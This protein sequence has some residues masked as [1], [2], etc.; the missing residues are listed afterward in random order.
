MNGANRNI[1]ALISA[2]LG[3]I[4][5]SLSSEP[6]LAV[7]LQEIRPTEKQ[8]TSGPGGRVLTNVGVWSPDSE[9]IVYDTRSDAAGDVFDGTRIEMVNIHTREVK[10]LYEAHHGACCGVATFH[11][12]EYKVIFILGPENPTVDWRYGP[13]HRQGVIVDVLKPGAAR[14]LDARDLTAPFTPGALRGGSHVH[15]W[16]A[17]GEWVSFTYH[18]ALHEPDL[19]DIGVSVPFR[20][21]RVKKDHPRNHDGT[22]FSVIV[23]QTVPQP[24]PGSDEIK[25]A[26]EESWVGDRGYERADGTRQKRALAF[27][28]HVVTDKGTVSSEVFIVDLPEDVTIPDRGP[29]Q[30]S[31]EQRPCPPKG[32]V[33]RRLTFTS[34]R[35]HPGLQGPR[36]WLRSSTDGSRIAFLMKDE[37]GIVQLWTV[38]PKGGNSVQVTHNPW[39]I[40][41]A[42]TW[43]PDGSYV[44]HVMD[45]C[46]A[47]TEAKSGQTIRLTPRTD[48]ARAPRPE[49]CVF[50][51]DGKK[52]AFVRRVAAG[53]RDYN[54]VCVLFLESKL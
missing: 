3:W 8:V 54:Q 1:R 11:P 52:I 37:K 4:V 9:W 48:N 41:S 27:Q 50:S 35:A 40:A 20:P 32:A 29:L 28:G 44:A 22:C 15:V 43:S 19:R 45:N 14:S 30:G 17:S 25:R 21:V 23:T 24:K 2:L 51:P 7:S 42:F 10:L 31:H 39:P 46:V 6:G 47:L 33:Q 12:F 38:S 18:D 53:D 49:A 36:H 5:M 34:E 16:D 13:A 26:C